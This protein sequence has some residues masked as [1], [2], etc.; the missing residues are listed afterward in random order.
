MGEICAGYGVH[1]YPIVSSAR[2]F[3]ALWKRAY[4]KVSDWLGAVVYEDPWRAGGHNGLSNSE[5]PRA[6]EDPYPRVLELRNVM[7][8]MG[9]GEMPIIM[10]GGV[11]YLR[12]WKE[13]IGNK[14]LGP[15]AF[16]FGTRPLLTTESPIPESWKQRLLDILPGDVLLHRFS[17]TGFYSSAVK[18]RFLQELT[19]RSA[20]QVAISD[21]ADESS[22]R[23]A[24]FAYG[25]GGRGVWMSEAD[26]ERA[27]GWIAEGYGQPMRTPEQTLIF[28]TPE[29]ARQIRRDQADCMGCLSHCAFSN[30][31][32]RDDFTTASA[33]RSALVLHPEDAAEHCPRA[34]RPGGRADVRGS[35]RLQVPRRSLLRQR[36]RSERAAVGPT[37]PDRPLGCSP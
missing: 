30:W 8:K 14:E 9:L 7:R 15:I 18:N 2:A 20:R 33:G 12:D 24:F 37:H 11:W 4:S 6:P 32:D 16:Q 5:D 23:T 3:N 1:Y 35:Q 29:S 28:V 13:W 36:L 27:R 31:K 21:A 19:E 34:D 26:L 10:A 22:G 25:R 17:P